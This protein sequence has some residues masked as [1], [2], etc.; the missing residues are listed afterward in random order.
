VKTEAASRG[1]AAA[2]TSD[3]ASD[4]AASTFVDPRDGLSY[5][6]WKVGART[7]LAKNLAFATAGSYCYGDDPRNCTRDGRLYTFTAAKTA[8]APGWRLATDDDWKT[9]ETSLGMPASQLD[10]EGY[11]TVRGR[12]EGTLFKGQNAHMA[13]YRQGASYDAIG[14]RT[15]FWTATTR[16]ADVWRR[17]VATAETTIF[18][19][20]NPPD[21]FAISVRCVKG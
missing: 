5:P 14:D 1:D 8:C 19:F 11:S 12:N 18:R 4:G 13:G 20:T 6:T 15:Y 17:R 21:G 3:A 9:L 7:W 16:G 10:L 2:A